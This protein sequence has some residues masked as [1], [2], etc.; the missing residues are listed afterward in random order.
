MI[1]S[2]DA[3]YD[4]GEDKGLLLSS[5]SLKARKEHACLECGDTILKGDIYYK[6]VVK[7]DWE[8][9]LFVAKTCSNCI[10]MR[11]IFFKGGWPY[12]EI[13]DLLYEFILECNGQIPNSCIIDLPRKAKNKILDIIEEIIRE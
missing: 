1:C 10:A 6:E 5:A 11:D 4:G 3:G 9:G 7:Y 13:W 12:G 2:C 8:K